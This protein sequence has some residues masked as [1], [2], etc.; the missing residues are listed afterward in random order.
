MSRR[1]L[2]GLVCAIFLLTLRAT[3][4]EPKRPYRLPSVDIQQRILWGATCALPDGVGLAFGGEDQLA[5]DGRPHTRV[6]QDGEWTPIHRSLREANP[7]QALHGRAIELRD[8]Q[9]FAAARARF[10]YFEGLDE[11]AV[12]ERAG[13]ETLSL[14]QRQI[15][16]GLEKLL[17]ELNDAKRIAPLS[18]YQADQAARAIDALRAA[19]ERAAA[20]APEATPETIRALSAD[21]IRIDQAAELLD[22]EPPARALSPICYDP[23]TRL[24][25]LFGGDHC[26]Y[27]T[28]DTW[29]FDPKEQRWE[30]RHPPAAPPPRANHQ[31]KAN[32]G[33][34]VTL[35]GGYTYFSNT[36]YCGGQYV[37]IEDGPWVYDVAANRWTGTGE[38]AEDDT[39]VYRT[40]P[41]L[42]EYFLEGPPP[43]PAAQEKRL[44]ELPPNTW[45][46]MDPPLLP[47]LNRDWGSATLDPDRDLILRFSGGHS[48]HGGTDVLHYHLST[49]RWELPFP[50]EFPLGQLYSN[51]SYPEG[52]NFNRRPW[53]TGHTY[54]SYGYDPALKKMLFAGQKTHTYVYD[55]TT[56]DWVGRFT[57]PEGMVYN[58]CFYTITICPT[59][60]GSFAWTA[61]GGL[62]RFDAESGRWEDWPL[63]EGEL[64]GAVV[65]NS[66]L[67]YD[68]KRDRLLFW[69]KGY[70][71]KHTYDGRIY[72]VDL[73]R[74]QVAE[75]KPEGMAAAASIPYLCQIRYDE[76]HDLMLVGATLPPSPD[77]LRRTPAYDCAKNRWVSLKIT[78]DDPHGE[79]GRNVS[80]GMMY[81]RKRGLFW[82]V[83]TRS[84]VFALRLD[85][86]TADVRPLE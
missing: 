44:A 58:G 16:S 78:G 6:K 74:Q 3:A 25:V 1:A 62:F 68:S 69:R 79:R 15:V 37:D 21:A 41:F 29:V 55:P 42:P 14:L 35:T 17:A 48:A 11:D 12:A 66:T 7:L 34:T 49:N 22:A 56:A 33:G 64:P 13:G 57:K 52:Y 59:P 46:A 84:R 81:D 10:I 47:H 86:E 63:P 40:G 67:A 85:P 72:A 26:D 83:D 60:R 2:L 19:A 80:L 75:L 50:V 71:E 24:F 28:N 32:S 77:G 51:T 65:D 8:R 61:H 76:R 23:K 30:Q 45:V 9:R 54:Q 31:L 38:P 5:N 43:D 53:V 70:G 20:L 27:L 82:A 18:P 39:R 4:A 73:K 36:D